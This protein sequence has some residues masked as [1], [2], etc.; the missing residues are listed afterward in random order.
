MAPLQAGAGWESRH[1][2]GGGH[3]CRGKVHLVLYCTALYCTVLYC[4]VLSGLVHLLSSRVRES[5]K[6]IEKLMVP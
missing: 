5:I 2:G 4:I 1:L 3:E 6:F